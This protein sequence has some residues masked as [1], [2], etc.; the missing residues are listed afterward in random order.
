VTDDAVAALT[1]LVGLLVDESPADTVARIAAAA[2]RVV[3]GCDASVLAVA[4]DPPLVVATDPALRDAVGAAVAAGAADV[5]APALGYPGALAVPLRT[6]GATT[7][8]LVLYSR[9]PVLPEAAAASAALLA[10]WA[11]VALRNAAT[12]RAARADAERAAARDGTVDLAAGIVLAEQRS[13]PDEALAWLRERAS[14]RG[15]AVGDLARA[16]VAD[17]SARNT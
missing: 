7:G 12:Y 2:C 15:V 6:G 16:V 17:R 14:S 9:A 4:G 10:V 1:E 8:R 3:P 13:G 11:G 5:A